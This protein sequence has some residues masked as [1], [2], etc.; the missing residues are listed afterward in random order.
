MCAQLPVKV[1][2]QQPAPRRRGKGRWH[3]A[4]YVSLVRSSISWS[5]GDGAAFTP[6]GTCACCDSERWHRAGPDLPMG[7]DRSRCRGGALLLPP[8]GDL[9][10]GVPGA[11]INPFSFGFRLRRWFL[12][13]ACQTPA[14][15]RERKCAVSWSCCQ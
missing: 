11:S 9:S 1:T 15:I 13:L 3:F 4:F 12:C 10:W 7:T 5:W 8:N 6:H 14:Y 2:I